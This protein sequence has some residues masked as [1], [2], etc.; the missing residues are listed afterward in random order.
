[1]EDIKWHSAY[2]RCLNRFICHQNAEILRILP[3]VIFGTDL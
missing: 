2:D 1:M 3:H